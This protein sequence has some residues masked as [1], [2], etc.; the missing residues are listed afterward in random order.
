MEFVQA[1]RPIV[2]IDEPQS[3]DSTETSQEAIRAL[4]P[5][6]TL[7]YSA[8]HR[9]PY[10]LVYRLDPVRA[11]E[12]RLVKQIVV[13]SATA[14]GGASEA[15]VRVERIEYKPTIRAKVRIQV[16]SD[17]GPKDKTVTVKT[18]SDLYSLS[19]ERAGYRV[20]Y[21]VAEISAEPDNEHLRF[22]S[23]RVMRPGEE[24][25]GLREDIWRVEIKHTV[26]KHLDKELQLRGRGVKVLS[27][28]FVDR[29]ANYR[30]YDDAG[31]PTKG[32]FS[33]W[34]EQTL[35]QFARDARYQE[36]A[37]LKQ[38]MGQLHNGYFAADKPKKGRDHEVWKDTRGDTQADDEVYN[39]IM[40]DKERLLAERSERD[41]TT[42]T[43]FK[44]ARS[45]RRGAR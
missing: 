3:V 43:C 45:T 24:I 4:N 36:L 39:L 27:L 11:F 32:K 31:R 5:L 37:W 8:T 30:D 9:N 22:T 26:K 18:G 20:G 21:E 7:R 10:N 17:G 28:F 2:I 25:G 19:G 34:F 35:G 41:G 23:G 13:G 29:V 42:P 16:Q 38:P 15:Y 44:S 40:R 33:E 1:T 12:L 6:C 14:E